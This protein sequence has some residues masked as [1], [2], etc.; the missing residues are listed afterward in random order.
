MDTVLKNQSLSVTLSSVGAEATAIQRLDLDCA[1]LWNGDAKYWNS[2]SPVLFPMVCA[3]M[4]GE[5]MVDGQKYP[6]INHGFARKSEFELVEVLDDS[7]VY[8]LRFNEKTLTSYPFKFQLMI[9]YSLAANNLEIDYHV[10]N[11]DER[12]IYFQIGTHPGFN[13]PLDSGLTFE[14]YYLEFNK[15]EDLERRFM[16]GANVLIPGQ[17]DLIGKGVKKLPMTRE[18]FAAGALIFPLVK[19]DHIVLK[20]DKSP[21]AVSVSYENMHQLGIW[22]AKDA[23][24][25]CIEPW[26][27]LAD[28]DG[29]TGEF[30]DR[31]AIV[32]LAQGKTYHCRMVIETI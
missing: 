6:I 26:Q 24:Y 4:N 2:H 28:E 17:T 27:G 31:A 13:C 9:R 10:E 5:I 19:S 11:L 18:L 7:A 1:Y 8:R 3:A 20:S 25:V 23:P 16:N 30:K 32:S 22:Q 14:D 15:P 29:F 12:T 21:R